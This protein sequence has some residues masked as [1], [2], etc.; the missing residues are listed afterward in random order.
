MAPL[1][2]DAFIDRDKSLIEKRVAPQWEKQISYEA[3]DDMQYISWPD[4]SIEEWRRSDPS[5]IPFADYTPCFAQ[6]IKHAD[7][8]DSYAAILRWKGNIIEQGVDASF[9]QTGGQVIL[10]NNMDQTFSYLS[11]FTNL[12]RESKEYA[13]NRIMLWNLA[14]LQPHI[15]IFIPAGVKLEKAILLD[16]QPQKEYALFS[17]MISIVV[18][19][20]S[21]VSIVHTVHSDKK[22]SAIYNEGM[23]VI[24][25]TRAKVKI[26][27]M[28]QCNINWYVFAHYAFHVEEQA[29]VEHYLTVLG[30]MY[31]KYRV[32]ANLAGEY[33]QALLYGMYVPHKDQH[34][35]IRTIQRHL[36]KY[37]FSRAWYKGVINDQAHTVYQGLIRVEERGVHTDAY[38]TN[39]N[40]LLSDEARADSIPS[41]EIHTNELRC[42]HGS[43]TGCLDENQIFYLQ[44]RGYTGEDARSILTEAYLEEI[45][46]AYPT[47]LEKRIRENIRA[48]IRSTL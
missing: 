42:S 48:R 13:D 44:T 33:A 16:L 45:V 23:N 2:C 10:S 18:G 1:S 38:L 20:K 6:E 21:N 28:Q 30:A 34:I 35:D 31:A 36:D 24:A 43:T 27:S 41:L 47:P 14:L 3:L 7:V 25:S 37:T 39:N 5:H 4:R 26:F 19:E 22:S 9:Q 46:I 32:Q 8:S 15:I 17:P 12:L 40:V 29:T 11:R